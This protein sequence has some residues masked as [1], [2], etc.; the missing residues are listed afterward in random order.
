MEHNPPARSLSRRAWL[1]APAAGLYIADVGLTLAGQPTE[2]WA[3]DSTS[4]NEANPVARPLLVVGPWVF[5][6]LAVAWLAVVT[7]V[8]LLWRHRLAEWVAVVLTVGH[9]IAGGAWLARSGG[10]WVLAGCGYLAVATVVANWCW[11]RA[12]WVR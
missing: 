9:A 5:A 8:V 3:G 6:A 11:R 12:G 1:L 2:Y 7:A 4:A 10:W